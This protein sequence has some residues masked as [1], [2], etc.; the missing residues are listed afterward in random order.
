MVVK[1]LGKDI[2][3]HDITS[4]VID[5]YAAILDAKGNK[6]STINRQLSIISKVLSRAKRKGQID[7][8]PDIE[9]RRESAGRVRSISEEE[10]QAMLNFFLAKGMLRMYNVVQ[11]LLDTGIRV[12][13]LHKLCKK[14]IKLN[15][16]KN[17]V[18]YLYDTKNGSNR[19]VP[20]TTRAR[21]ALEEL[22][23]TSQSE[24]KI[25]HECYGWEIF[26][27]RKL[28]KHM[29]LEND[30]NFVPHI[31][32]HTCCTRLIQRDGNLKKV[33]KWMGHSTIQT[34]MR[35]THLVANDILHLSDLL[36][37]EALQQM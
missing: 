12:G 30:P 32:R 35:Y 37:E 17:G 15:E 24:D 4:K 21:K 14:D 7:R 5:N 28:K 3:L 19:V 20:L 11:L 2:K 27:W 34:T 8:M 1:A 18:I 6:G 16:G 10:E 36:E 23:K 9:R 13:E 33:Q 29:H 22:I 25:M 26:S 31:L